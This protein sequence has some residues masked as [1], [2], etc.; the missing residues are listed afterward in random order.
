MKIAFLY[1]LAALGFVVLL[2]AMVIF[3]LYVF[4]LVAFLTLQP[5]V[6]IENSQQI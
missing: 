2:R 4:A 3:V 5:R 6:V 1:V